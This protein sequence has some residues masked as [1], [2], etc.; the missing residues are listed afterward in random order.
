[1]IVSADKHGRL[2]LA[3]IYGGRGE[4]REISK[5]SAESFIKACRSAGVPIIRVFIDKDGSFYIESEDELPRNGKNFAVGG[6]ENSENRRN[7]RESGDTIPKNPKD[8]CRIPTYPVRL[9]GK[10]GFLVGGE[11]IEVRGAFPI[12]HGDFGE[13]G[14]VQGALITAGVGLFGNDTRSGAILS[15]KAY[16]KMIAEHYGVPTV[17]FVTVTREDISKAINSC[18]ALGYPLIVK[19]VS[20]GSSIGISQAYSKDELISSLELAF[21]YSE[22]AVCEKFIEDK[23]ELE[24]AYFSVGDKRLIT[25]PAE[26]LV[27]G[28][29]DYDK[30]YRLPTEVI[31][32]AEIRDTVREKIISYTDTLSSAFSVKHISRFDYFLLP[33][34][35]I[36]L[37]E[38][39]T[40]PGMT[41]SSLYLRMLDMAGLPTKE[42]ALLVYGDLS[43]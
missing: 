42:L 17:P 39:N 40:C 33:S 21:S 30:K 1:M 13:D 2:P 9:L 19:P 23:R 8:L 35:E 24:C 29:Y 18:E 11:V 34:G 26:V 28:F 3:V 25:P 7:L 4:E 6:D 10:S 22:R 31:P 16:T 32:V 15:D 14:T 37:N 41:E 20:L 5:K 12:L 27:K 36:F 43:W 38:V